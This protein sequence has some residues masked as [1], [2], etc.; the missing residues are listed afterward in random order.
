MDIWLNLSLS[1]SLSSRQHH[2][3]PCSYMLAAQ[4]GRH[5]GNHPSQPNSTTDA[6]LRHLLLWQ[7][8]RTIFNDVL[9]FSNGTF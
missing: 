1:L 3:G 4:G 7:D 2:T 6:C 9:V 8:G 5:H